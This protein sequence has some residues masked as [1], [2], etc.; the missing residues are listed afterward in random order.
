MSNDRERRDILHQMHCNV[1]LRQQELRGENPSEWEHWLY[2]AI[3]LSGTLKGVAHRFKKLREGTL[4]TAMRYCSHSPVE[5][6]PP[7]KLTCALGK[8]VSECP[9]LKDIFGNIETASQETLD[10]LKASVCVA[11]IF[12]ET[13]Q[14]GCPADTSEG[15]MMDESD[16]AYWAKTYAYMSMENPDEAPQL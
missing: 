15:Y 10:E 13:V 7:Q 2:E 5:A 14:P 1:N 3:Y 8:D 16:K 6:L 12:R 9:I 4:P 11:H